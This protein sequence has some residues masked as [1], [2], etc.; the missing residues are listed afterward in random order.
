MAK[1]RFLWPVWQDTRVICSASP[2]R[3]GE[4]QYLSLSH[5]K[6]T[7]CLLEAIWP[8]SLAPNRLALGAVSILL[9]EAGSAAAAIT[10]FP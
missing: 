6:Q 1:I 7:M 8:H 3:M 5:A 2:Y 4:A 9:G 10:S